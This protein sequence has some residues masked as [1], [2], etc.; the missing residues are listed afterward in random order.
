MKLEN[1]FQIP[2]KR[3]QKR[4]SQSLYLKLRKMIYHILI[5]MIFVLLTVLGLMFYYTQKYNKILHNVTTASEFN[6]DF[7]ENI[8]QEMYYYVVGSQYSTG[9]PLDDVETAKELAQSLADTTVEYDSS[10]AIHA[11]IVLC[12]N[13]TDK[14]NQIAKTESYDER[15]EQLEN[16]IYI[17]TELIQKYMYNY[18]YYES[19]QL[20]LLHK[21][22]Q[23]QVFGVEIAA[24]LIILII[25]FRTMREGFKISKS[26]LLPVKE[27]NNRVSAI[28]EGD[29]TVHLPVDGE[30]QEL[31]NLGVAFES[32]TGQ[33]NV[34]IEQNREEQKNLR[35]AELALLQSQIN[36]HFLYNTL[37]AVVWLVETGKYEQ[38]IDMITSLSD[39]FRTSLSKGRN[40]ITIQEEERHITSYLQIQQVRYKDILEYDIQI[41]DNIRC[42][43]IP[44]LTLQPLIEN[45]IYHGIKTKRGGGKINVKG[46]ICNHDIVIEVLDNG[47]GMGREKLQ[48]IQSALKNNERIGFGMITVHERLRLLFGEPYG[49]TVDSSP[50]DGTK[51]SVRIPCRTDLGDVII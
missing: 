22:I 40:I 50:E 33:L 10:K 6:Q 21:G 12:D 16:N 15:E 17:I 42:F 5:P 32:M 51:I 9:L 14:I 47:F 39:Y 27:L 20:D 35:N 30:I 29:L 45:A 13:L 37:D 1:R 49:L 4:E 24:A 43:Q 28:A 25:I 19:V 18:L 44:K 41:E 8:D 23:R 11:V 38:S 46:F 36:P 34:L 26:I 48:E 2:N 3:S 7:K 31:S